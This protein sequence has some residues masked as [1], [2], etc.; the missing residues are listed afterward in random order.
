MRFVK[1][2]TQA[3]IRSDFSD[4]S[5]HAIRDAE[6]RPRTE[7]SECCALLR[8]APSV[9]PSSPR[10]REQQ[11]ESRQIPSDHLVDTE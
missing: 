9:F 10:P 7:A 5:L 11:R 3:V 8:P 4:R 1:A 2:R 6:S